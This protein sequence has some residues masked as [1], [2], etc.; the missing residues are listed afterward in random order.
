MIT[1]T[2]ACNRAAL[3]YMAPLGALEQHASR[4]RIIRKVLPP[5]QTQPLSAQPGVEPMPG[6]VAAGA[7]AGLPLPPWPRVPCR[8]CPI[9]C[10]GP[11]HEV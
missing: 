9:L 5:T 7:C 2:V 10:G 6:R 3:T 8:N 1:F 4:G 11:R